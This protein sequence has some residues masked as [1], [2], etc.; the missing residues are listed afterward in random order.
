M[1]CAVS[2]SLG[3]QMWLPGK[4]PLNTKKGG[5]HFL[6]L[7]LLPARCTG[8][9]DVSE[10]WMQPHKQCE[11]EF[12]KYL[13]KFKS[14]S[15]PSPST[16]TFSFGFHNLWAWREDCRDSQGLLQPRRCDLRAEIEHR[17]MLGAASPA[18]LL[19]QRAKASEAHL[20]PQE[21]SREWEHPE[22]PH[23]THCCVPFQSLPC[24]E[25]TKPMKAPTP[26]GWVTCDS[27]IWLAELVL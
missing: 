24:Q 11:R 17:H 7:S 3:L 10:R 14:K 18:P 22:Q 21:I 8:K 2:C 9:P 27:G 23:N 5:H 25:C 4:D 19:V 1:I 26:T 13:S 12:G 16:R 6:T 20:L 15:Q